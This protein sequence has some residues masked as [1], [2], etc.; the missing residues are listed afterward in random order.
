MEPS[1]DPS[2]NGGTRY[3]PRSGSASPPWLTPFKYLVFTAAQYIQH[4]GSLFPVEA[5]DGTTSELPHITDCSHSAEGHDAFRGHI[6]TTTCDAEDVLLETASITAVAGTPPA[7]H[8]SPTL[9]DNSVLARCLDTV[10]EKL[11]LAD[12]LTRMRIEAEKIA[13]GEL[14]ANFRS[15]VRIRAFWDNVRAQLLIDDADC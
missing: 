5:T 1:R 11:M 7:Q 8:D 3:W 13:R 12:S 10:D 15:E 6:D 9:P 4:I 14:P 2:F